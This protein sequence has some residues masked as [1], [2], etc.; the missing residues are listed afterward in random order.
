MSIDLSGFRQTFVEESLDDIATVRKRLSGNGCPDRQSLDEIFRVVGA[1]NRGAG[2]F[3]FSQLARITRLLQPLLDELQRQR[4]PLTAEL[5]DLLLASCELMAVLIV[6]EPGS[7]AGPH[8]QAVAELSGRLQAALTDLASLPPSAAEPITT[9]P[10]NPFNDQETFPVSEAPDEQSGGQTAADPVPAVAAPFAPDTSLPDP[11]AP[12]PSDPDPFAPD[13]SA[14]GPFSAAPS[15]PDP[16]TPDS[17]APD[18]FS[19]DPS[20]PDPFTP[21]ASASDPFVTDPFA[22]DP[23]DPDPFSPD[24][25]TS[26]PFVTDPFASAPAQS[27]DSVTVPVTDRPPAPP[28][29][30]MSQFSMVFFEESFEGIEAMEAGLLALEGGDGEALSD[31]FRAAHSIK[32]GAGMFGYSAIVDFSHLVETLLGELRSGLRPISGELIRLLLSATDAVRTLL[33]NAQQDELQIPEPVQQLSDQLQA[34]LTPVTAVESAAM[35]SASIATPATGNQPAEAGS[36]WRIEFLP[37]PQL[38]RNGNEPLHLFSALAELGQLSISC[39]SGDLPP[40]SELNP[41][42]CHL[43]WELELQGA[44]PRNSVEE[45]FDWTEGDCKLHISPLQTPERSSPTRGTGTGSNHDTSFRERRDGDRRRVSDRR[46]GAEATSIRVSTDKVDT[47]IN[48]VGELVITRSMLS[49]I[50]PDKPLSHDQL[51]L[52]REGLARLERNSR[53]LQE[54]VMRI[55]MLPIS[56]VFNRFPRLVHDLQATLGKQI[57]LEIRGENTELDKTL[58]ER[59]SDPLVHLVRNAIDHGIETPDQRQAAGKAASGRLILEARHQEGN[60]IIE[61]S[62]D[63]RGLDA[64]RIV[65]RARQQG[66]VADN[67]QLR[68]Q[69]IFDLIMQP[70]F[71]TAETVSELSGRG[72]GMDVVRRNINE[73]GGNIEISSEPGQG[74]RFRIRLPLTLAILDGQQIRLG[75]QVCIIP[76]VSIVESLQLSDEEIRAVA[77]RDRLCSFRDE[78]IPLISLRRLMG[79]P[80]APDR[81]GLVVI[82]EANSQRYGLLV[83]ALLNQQ[84]VVIKSLEENYRK[85]E[86]IAGATILGNGRVGLILDIGGIL[87]LHRRLRNMQD[88]VSVSNTIQLRTE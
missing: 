62:D 29:L 58:M 63:G 41:T 86:G 35:P 53:E 49:Q 72:V 42:D 24:C 54:D 14:P 45:V 80:P 65:A 16:F 23:S 20:E 7:E 46:A 79:H 47:L 21:D 28:G 68:Q 84:Q 34:Q 4:R 71:S 8:A 33:L 2:I 81:E 1:L 32:G 39:N 30:D 9:A 50:D 88:P 67:E 15:E 87:Q 17:S 85:V 12:D 27:A 44:I 83:D 43:S 6:S 66:L 74:T 22:T 48:R 37:F 55:R 69:Q 59:I 25:S 60:I 40:L 61:I 64:D 38:L 26:D 78:Y 10:D 31:V 13:S 36:G 5:L 51:E 19:A 3:G 52:L 77:G 57:E 82:V 70:G 75:D 73:L 56:F 11:F 76:L 18:P